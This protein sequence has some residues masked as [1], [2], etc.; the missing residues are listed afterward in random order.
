VTRN[1][2]R[3]GSHPL[4]A[5]LL[6]PLPG[7][8]GAAALGGHR[9]Q[10]RESAAAARA[11]P[12]HP[13][14]VFDEPAAAAVQDRRASHPT[15][16]LLRAPAGRE[17]L[18]AAAPWADPWA[19]RATRVAPDLSRSNRTRSHGVGNGGRPSGGVSERHGQGDQTRK[20]GWHMP[21]LR[22][23]DLRRWDGRGE[24]AD[25]RDDLL[26]PPPRRRRKCGCIGNPGLFCC[27]LDCGCSMVHRKE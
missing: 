15:C 27:R 14:L 13:E 3:S 2:A 20:R 26:L 16:S 22:E 24:R 4:G 7:Q 12:C 5:P 17:L 6:P 11:P 18:D 9:V 25:G 1:L 21:G 10:P 8:R 19:H 23:N